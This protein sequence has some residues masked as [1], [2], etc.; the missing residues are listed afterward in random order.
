MVVLWYLFDTYKNFINYFYFSI[1]ISITIIGIDA[2]IQYTTGTNLI[3]IERINPHRLSGIFNDEFI[4]GSYY[5]RM[6]F[7]FLDYFF[8]K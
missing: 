8:F 2:M 6:Y 5:L 1:M 3:G 4:L 7:I